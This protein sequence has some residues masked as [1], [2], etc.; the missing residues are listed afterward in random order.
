MLSLFHAYKN[1]PAIFRK[2]SHIDPYKL[3]KY[4]SL[5]IDFPPQVA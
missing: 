3:M 4:R 1:V 2:D 5:L